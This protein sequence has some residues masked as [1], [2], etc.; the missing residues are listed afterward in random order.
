MV[1]ICIKHKQAF[2]L[3]PSDLSGGT[4]Y[5]YC[6]DTLTVLVLTGYSHVWLWYLYIYAI[7]PCIY[8]DSRAVG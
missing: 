3:N 7:F 5:W 1:D 8:K 6:C 4:V 2:K